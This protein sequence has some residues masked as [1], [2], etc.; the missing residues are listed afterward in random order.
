VLVDHTIRTVETSLF[1]GAILVVVVLLLMLGNWRAALIVALAIPLSLLMAMTGMVQGRVAGNLMSLG[2]ID[3]GLIIDG[4]VVMVETSSPSS[5]EKQHNFERRLTPT[6]RCHMKCSSASEV[7]SPMFFGVLIIT[8]VYFPILALTGIE[9][10]MFKPMAITVIFALVGAL[11]LALTL[12]P[13]L[14]S[15]LLGGTSGRTAF[16]CRREKVYAP[17]QFLPGPLARDGPAIALFALAGVVFNGSAPSL[18][19][20]R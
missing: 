11:A 13:A 3:F 7:A 12:M 2:A 6:E 19:S 20:T 1:E 8:V 17:P 15:Y 16:S 4:A 14:C 9:G 18:C 10:K 5:P